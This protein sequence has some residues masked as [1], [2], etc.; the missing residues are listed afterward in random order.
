[1]AAEKELQRAQ[2][3]LDALPKNNMPHLEKSILIELRG[4]ESISAE[5]IK[6]TIEKNRVLVKF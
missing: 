1:M 2:I 5:L 3:K 4:M 6:D